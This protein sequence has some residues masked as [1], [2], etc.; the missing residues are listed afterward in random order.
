[1]GN[2]ICKQSEPFKH[3]CC[4][5]RVCTAYGKL[6]ISRDNSFRIDLAPSEQGF[7]LKGKKLFPF[8]LDLFIG[9]DKKRY[10]VN[11]FLIS[12]QKHVFW[13]LI[14]SASVRCF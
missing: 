12:P 1:M 5:V 3:S 10:E 7:T 9:L 4:L 14:R 2:P 13:V 8:R 6:I 11:I